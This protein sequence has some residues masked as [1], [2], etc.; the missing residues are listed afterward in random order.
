MGSMTQ[1]GVRRDG[2]R[3]GVVE[4]KKGACVCVCVGVR[5]LCKA[6]RERERDR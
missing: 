3:C 5:K 1:R 2:L 6:R 4:G